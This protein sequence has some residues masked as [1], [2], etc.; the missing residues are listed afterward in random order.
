MCACEIEIETYRK[1]KYEFSIN[2]KIYNCKKN[3]LY[4]MGQPTKASISCDEK[5]GELTHYMK[6]QIIN[7]LI[8]IYRGICFED[9]L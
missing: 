4:E 6:Y 7:N 3:D 2:G 8:Y 1:T 9:Q 5:G